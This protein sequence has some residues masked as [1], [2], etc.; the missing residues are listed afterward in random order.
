MNTE[1]LVSFLISLFVCFLDL[2]PGVG[3]LGH[4]VDLLLVLLF[5]IIYLFMTMLG[6]VA[7]QALL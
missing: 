7:T 5:K 2:Y 6:L 3:L 1:V 4:M